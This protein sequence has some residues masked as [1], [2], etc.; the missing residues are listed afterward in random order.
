MII[1][2]K[3]YYPKAQACRF[4]LGHELTKRAYQDTHSNDCNT[5]NQRIDSA[6]QDAQHPTLFPFVG[7]PREP[8]PTGLPFRLSDY[9]ELVDWTGRTIREDKRGFVPAHLPHILERRYIDAKQWRTLST[10]FEVHC[11]TLVG[12][13][14]AQRNT[15]VLMGY[16][17]TP[18][19][20]RTR[21]LFQ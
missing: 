16:Q 20:A 13:A 12:E 19:L 4:V 18:G 21:A 9:I 17:R 8:M 11:K 2:K 10:Q 5:I 7:N 14:Q 1:G 15:A 6:Q 3:S